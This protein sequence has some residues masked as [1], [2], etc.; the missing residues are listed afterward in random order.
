M[1]AGLLTVSTTIINETEFPSL[2]NRGTTG[3]FANLPTTS[4][5]SSNQSPVP[6][7]YAPNNRPNYANLMRSGSE[8]LGSSG[9][10]HIQSEDFPALPGATSSAKIP[11]AFA[12]AS[13]RSQTPDPAGATHAQTVMQ[14]TTDIANSTTEGRYTEQQRDREDGALRTGII[15][16]PD[17]EVTNIPPGM[18]NDQYGMAGLVTYLRAVDNPAIVALALGHDLTTLGLNLNAPDR[19]LY[20]TFGGPWADYPCRTQDMDAKVPVEYLTNATI[21]DKLPNIK[22]HKLGEDVLFYLFYNCPGEVYQV[23]AAVELYSR[24]WR[25]HK[26]ECVWLT[27]SQYGGV[28]EQTGTYEKGSYNVF[29]PIQWRKIPKDMTLEYKQLEERPKLPASLQLGANGASS[30]TQPA[31]SHSMAPGTLPLSS[32]STPVAGQPTQLS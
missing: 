19:M 11:S 15:T 6:P 32:S 2:V 30:N 4:G 31:T 3:S 7:G 26:G 27:R 14:L 13:G 21:R 24:D 29:D 28:K 25:F 1:S 22:L 10:F 9:E 20:T 12:S 16:H 18:L 17:G 5:Y 8:G 23:A